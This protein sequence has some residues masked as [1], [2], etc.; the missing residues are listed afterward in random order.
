MNELEMN[1]MKTLRR[2]PVFAR[3]LLLAVLCLPA[4]S[5]AAAPDVW[6]G[7]WKGSLVVT[8]GPGAGKTLLCEFLISRSGA[9]FA[10]TVACPG[11]G[12]VPFSG[13]GTGGVS[14][15]A[16]G[17]VSFS[18]TRQGTSAAGTWTLPAQGNTQGNKGTWSITRA[19]A[20]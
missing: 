7:R 11:L 20:Q 8:A 18:G 3:L 9:G 19:T 16:T 12:P 15:S 13:S 6:T 2:R 14:G 17:G 4:S 10:G 5:G 1:S